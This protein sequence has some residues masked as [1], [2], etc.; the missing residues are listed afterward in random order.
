MA[1]PTTNLSLEIKHQLDKIDITYNPDDYLQQFQYNIKEYLIKSET[2]G[3]LIYHS[4]GTGKSI[5]AAAL[6]EYY[7]KYDPNRQIIILLAKSLQGNF[8]KNI[9]KYMHNNKDAP[10]NE[11]GKEFIAETLESKYKFVSLNAGN[12]YTQISKAKKSTDELAFDKYLGSLNEHISQGS[13]FLEN[14]LL[15]IDE[16]HNLSTAIKNG[17]K[18]AIK[19]YTTLMKTRNIKLLFLTG[20]PIVNTPFELVPLFNMLKGNMF[21]DKNKYTLFPE[22][23]IEFSKLFLEVKNKDTLVIKNKDIFQNRI[24]GLVSY[25]GDFYFQNTVK[26]DFPVE[27]PTVIETVNMSIPQFIRYQQTRDLERKENSNAFS[28][29]SASDTFNFKDDSQ[30]SSSYRIRSRQ[31]SNYYI[32]EYAVEFNAAKTSVEKFINRITDVDLENLTKFSPKFKKIFENISSRSN[33]LAV[34]Y[35]EFVSGEGINLFS[36]MLEKVENYVYWRNNH[37]ENSYDLKYT[38]KSS[39]KKTYAIISGNVPYSEREHIIKTF[40]DKNNSDG[41]YIS[42]LLISKSGAEGLSLRNVRSI[43]IMEPFWNYARIEQI[44]ARGSRFHSHTDLPEKERNIQ[45]YIYIS[46]YPVK[47]NVEEII[48]KTTDEELLFISLNGKKIRDQFEMALIESSIDCS[49]NYKNLDDTIKEKIKCYLCT[50]NNLPLYSTD[51]RRDV[52]VNNC[53][54]F[55][56]SS[57]EAQMIKLPDNDTEYYYTKNPIKVYV[58][59]TDVGGYTEMQKNDVNYS[60]LI[61]KILKFE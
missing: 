39:N 11:K 10:Y 45:P 22:N 4:P 24:T 30:T 43:H 47:F 25:Y 7:R 23:Q 54:P 29:S 38:K 34:V 27:F 46:T 8:E 33:Q 48:E 18:N 55:V 40:N 58:F 19:L 41:K 6:S 31:V 57:V 21:Y 50:P 1:L 49:L 12:M 26:K 28:K 35:S 37:E 36:N 2:R 42:L 59:N 14:S 9:K 20:T 15:I 3:L 32:P 61:K 56:A 16:A 53:I 44:I 60:S 13:R 52:K 17:S 51:I 5:L